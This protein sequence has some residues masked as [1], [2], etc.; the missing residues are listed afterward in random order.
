M[1]DKEF[2][3]GKSYYTRAGKEAIVDDYVEGDDYPIKGR[4]ETPDDWGYRWQEVTWDLEGKVYT[5]TESWLDMFHDLPSPPHKPLPGNLARTYDILGI[6]AYVTDTDKSEFSGDP[7]FEQEVADRLENQLSVN[8]SQFAGILQR[9][10]PFLG[11]DED[12]DEM[13][14][15]GK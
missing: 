14:G 3:V 5:W 4:A 6:A 9:L 11:A 7:E 13:F 2:K 8:L 12:F 15:S 1:T 10:Y